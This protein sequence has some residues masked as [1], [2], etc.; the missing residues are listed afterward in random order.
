MYKNIQKIKLN[1]THLKRKHW[2]YQVND[3]KRLFCLTSRSG[4]PLNPIS[5]KLLHREYQAP[6]PRWDWL[7]FFYNSHPKP[8]EHFQRQQT[9]GGGCSIDRENADGKTQSERSPTRGWSWNIYIPSRSWQNAR[10]YCAVRERGGKHHP[11]HFWGAGCY[12]GGIGR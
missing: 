10:F 7:R 1:Y 6:S 9:G 8:K 2:P 11:Q 4:S 12:G 5:P 3:S